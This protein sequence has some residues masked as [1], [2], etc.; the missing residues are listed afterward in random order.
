L[1]NTSL[2]KWFYIASRLVERYRLGRVYLVLLIALAVGLGVATYLSFTGT[3]PLHRNF[4]NTFLLL[5]LDLAVL[6]LL[7]VSVARLLI[8][9]RRQVSTPGSRLR[10]R[11]VRWFGLLVVVPSIIITIFSAF[12]FNLGVESW[13]SDHVKTAIKNSQFVANAYLEEHKKG[14]AKDVQ[15]IAQDLVLEF[16]VLISN[17]QLFNDV[18]NR[19]QEQRSF[20]E[21]IVFTSDFHVLARTQLT[22]NLLYELS[23]DEN[24]LERAR[25][26]DV[27]ISQSPA[28]DRVR[29]L[30]Q[31]SPIADTF[32]LVGRLV[33]PEVLNHVA[34]TARASSEYFNLEAQRWE[35]EIQFILIFI[36]FSLL[37]LMVVIWIGMAFANYLAEPIGQLIEAADRIRTGDL[38]VRVNVADERDEIGILSR[39]FNRMA[40]QVEHQRS[41]LMKVNKKLDYR[42]HFIE[43][44]LA[45]VTA[46]VVGLDKN[47]RINIANASASKMLG[48]NLNKLRTYPFSEVFPEIAEV[49]RDAKNKDLQRQISVIREGR[50]RLLLVQVTI[51][52]T[53]EIINGYVVTFD[54]VTELVN[55][56]KKSA[57]ADV[58][59]RIAHEIKNP[60]TPIQLSAERLVSKFTKKFDKDE[61][62]NF[63]RYVETISRQ[64][65]HIGKMVNEF[66]EFARMPEP[67]LLRENIVELC[68]QA[69]FLQKQGRRNVEILL[70]YENKAVYID[71]DADQISRVLTNLI[72]NAIE[73]IEQRIKNDKKNNI[74]SIKKGIIAVNV[75]LVKNGVLITIDDNGIG[76]PEYEREKLT[77]PYVTNREKGTG[78]GLAIV[79]RIMEDHSGRL[80]LEDAPAGGARVR[81]WFKLSADNEEERGI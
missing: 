52:K 81:L 51:D 50:T 18:L 42:R 36:I 58:A 64:V 22:F 16:P 34:A 65:Q 62:E 55:A 27:V 32:L 30:V 79:K 46:G 26:G 48:M 57:W 17:P 31:V 61:R 39:A 53:D 54:D 35:T 59:R 24:D 43:M 19:Y 44:V 74:Q 66:S 10:A 15:A 45:G 75:T 20:S 12:F 71:C 23:V 14:V 78:L 5:N 73:S 3:S 1:N 9:M 38:S 67:V 13:F 11:L 80:V 72:K 4:K 49:M 56:Q 68:E 25:N 63:E 69:V 47:R 8:L 40:T 21:A 29:A 77:D 60:L 2:T 6:L 33:D 76:F 7:S 28:G 41:E 70:T 37:L